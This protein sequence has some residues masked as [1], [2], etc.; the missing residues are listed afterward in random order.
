[1]REPEKRKM[2]KQCYTPCP[3]QNEFILKK[4][5]HCVQYLCNVSNCL[6]SRVFWARPVHLKPL[7]NTPVFKKKEIRICNQSHACLD[8]V[9]LVMRVR[10]VFTLCGR[11]RGRAVWQSCLPGP[12]HPSIL[13]TPQSP[14][15]RHPLKS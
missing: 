10:L 15:S 8:Q 13:H 4:R 1:M 12:C 11:Y 5:H 3:G 7:I 6:I 2:D 9:R 14:S